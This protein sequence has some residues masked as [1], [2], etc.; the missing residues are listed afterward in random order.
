MSIKNRLRK[1]EAKSPK[2]ANE[3]KCSRCGALRPPFDEARYKSMSYD[4]SVEYLVNFYCSPCV[5][6]GHDTEMS[7]K[8]K[9][10]YS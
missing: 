2:P 8:L 9:A 3:Q 7:E 1:L 5:K 10:V 6:C 4:A